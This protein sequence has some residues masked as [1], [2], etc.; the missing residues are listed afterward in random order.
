MLVGAC[1]P[2][3][4]PAGPPIAAPALVEDAVVAA[5]GTR[6]PLRRFAPEGAPRGVMLALHGFNDHSGNFLAD[7]IAA[8]TAAGQ[9]VY[10]YDQRGFGRAPNR[11]VWP[12]AETLAEDAATA[13]RLIRARHPGLTL[14]LMGE[15]MGGAV[16]ILAAQA[17]P[18]VDRYVLLA[19]AIWSRAQMNGVMRGGMWLAARTVP[20]LR[21]GGGV[22]GIVASDNPEALRR[23]SRDPLVIRNT[24]VDA[25]LGLVELMDQAAPLLPRCCG[26]P[27]LLLYGAQD[28]L[29]P[30]GPTRAALRQVRP[31]EGPRVGVHGDGFHL[32]LAG[33]GRAVVVEDILAF[34]DDPAAPL[35]SAADTAVGVWL[36]Q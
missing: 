13:L 26:A 6:L 23:L 29:V 9:L 1:A 27:T 17:R 30:P 14:T 5:D 3:V 31:G 34:I 21:L 2:V 32:L 24:R 16:A 19:P 28:S 8:L 22:G 4:R 15:S 25:V 7:S 36:D 33:R 18:P 35:P 10:A 20:Q 11:G 12:G